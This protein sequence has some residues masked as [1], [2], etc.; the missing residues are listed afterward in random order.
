[1][2]GHNVRVGTWTDSAIFCYNRGCRCN[3]CYVKDIV[4]TKCRM[5]SIVMELV[6]K[7]GV[8]APEKEKGLSKNEY[9]IIT[10]ILNGCNTF[11]DIALETN[12]S[13]DSVKTTTS[14]MYILAEADGLIYRNLRYKLP[15]FIDWVRQGGME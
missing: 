10:A 3:G 14:R 15:E 7:Y 5:K 11:D 12:I 2:N 4:E 9:K 1:M 6:R 13:R 8:P